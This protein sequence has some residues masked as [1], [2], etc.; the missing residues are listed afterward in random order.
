MCCSSCRS[1]PSTT[2]AV[3]CI[4]AQKVDVFL[5]ALDFDE[6]LL[7]IDD[8]VF[9]YHERNVKCKKCARKSESRR[10]RPKLRER[11][12]SGFKGMWVRGYGVEGAVWVLKRVIKIR[13]TKS[14]TG[15]AGWTIMKKT[16]TRHLIQLCGRRLGKLAMRRPTCLAPKE[17]RKRKDLKL[18]LHALAFRLASQ[19][20]IRSGTR[21]TKWVGGSRSQTHRWAA[22]CAFTQD[23]GYVRGVAPTHK[24]SPGAKSSACWKHC[25]RM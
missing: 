16:T 9:E 13:T 23:D 25:S 21:Y 15:F 10:S 14:S 12:A 8:V 7:N 11:V 18:A 3:L 1:S 24:H 5:D 20:A 22:M 4:E 2:A 19:S 6:F 17:S